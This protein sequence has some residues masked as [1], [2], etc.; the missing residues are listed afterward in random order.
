M[1]HLSDIYRTSLAL[2][3]DL[4]Q[5]TMVYA[6]R[7]A[8]L[9]D[10]D[11]AF[12]LSY[13]K[14]PFG[15]GYVLCA[16]LASVVDL[17]ENFRF[18]ATDIEYLSG[19][20]GS[21]DKVLFDDEF[22]QYLAD[23]EFRVDIDAIPE[24]SVVFPHEPLLRVVGPL[25]HAQLLETP[26]LDILNFNSLI[27]TK[28]SRVCHAAQRDPV[29]EFGLRRAQGIDGGISAARAAYIGGCAGTSNVLAG[30][31]YG[32]PVKGTHAHSWV[33]SFDDEIEAF[34][35]YAD[36]LPNNCMLLVDTYETRSG[37]RNAARIGRELA[38]GGHRLLGVRLDSG[39]LAYLSNE[40]RRILDE[41]GLRETMIIGSGDL[42]ER[43]IKSLKQQGAP[44]S[45][46]G[47]GT[48]L[49]TA[50]DE[51]AL[52]GIY[53][54]GALKNADGVW[55]PR[56]KLSDESSKVSTPG[57]LQ[58]RRYFDTQGF[59]ADAIYDEVTGIAEDEDSVIV[60]P[61]D[62]V[63]RKTIER[64]TPSETLLVPIFRRGRRVVEPESLSA[65]RAR[66]KTQLKSLHPS[67]LRFENPYLYPAG[68]ELRL[69][70]LKARLI[71]ETKRRIGAPA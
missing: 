32:I 51:P 2:L 33:M 54:L 26:L 18:E 23:F 30:K 14:N 47:V 28:A 6:Y 53:K 12:N 42:D 62:P 4:Y 34:R 13:R 39:D 22:L 52:G 15:G 9:A 48:K 25:A 49:V 35:A 16:G 37:V 65:I 17:V 68:L 41:A 20:K 70:E 56:L 58:V 8:G 61:A 40:A 11:A 66:A 36:A 50:Y 7:K 67:V 29:L 64:D 43:L 27:A 5:L 45:V 60:D 63:R 31:L 55:E 46:W 69:Y 71:A 57:L 44:I 10:R 38:A 19:L 59:L 21:D 1:T 3:T 24:G